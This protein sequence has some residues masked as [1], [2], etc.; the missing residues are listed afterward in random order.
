MTT[1]LRM[2]AWAMALGLVHLLATVLATVGQHGIRYVFSARDEHKTMTGAGA[3]LN[4]AFSNFLE[5]FAFFVAA[6]LAV[7]M[8][9][10]HSAL[11]VL[12]AQLYVWARV[13][14]VPLYVAG[15][16][17]ARTL[18]WLVAFAGIVLV[19]TGLA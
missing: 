6:V 14:Y 5:T 4:R 1:E 8:L 19:A 15:V 11:T 7:Q 3:K 18:C 10:R 9:D 16:P 12:G 17:V 2:L 13:V